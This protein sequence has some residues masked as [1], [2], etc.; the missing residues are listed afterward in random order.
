M[1]GC[2]GATA[3]AGAGGTLCGSTGGL[4]TRQQ[5]PQPVCHHSMFLTILFFFFFVTSV[6]LSHHFT[7]GFSQKLLWFVLV[8]A[9]IF[10]GHGGAPPSPA[11]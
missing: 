4:G 7:Q 9:S 11:H 3:A 2:D 8:E 10:L 6:F 1:C 5:L